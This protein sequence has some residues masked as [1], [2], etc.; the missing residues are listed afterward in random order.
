MKTFSQW[1]NESIQLSE[2]TRNEIPPEMGTTPIRSGYIRLYHQTDLKNVDNIRKEGLLKAKSKGEQLKEPK[3]IWATKEPFHGKNT[4]LAT[5]E[6]SIPEEYYRSPSYVTM[7]KVPPENII[8]IH[9]PWHNLA[10]DL[11]KEYPEPNLDEINDWMTIN[12][13]YKKAA[14]AY[15]KHMKDLK[16]Q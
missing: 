6:F 8:D 3:V 15:V 14:L 7:D 16:K 11:I 13:D 10:R 2:N 4:D 5:V 9:L 12:D 1:I